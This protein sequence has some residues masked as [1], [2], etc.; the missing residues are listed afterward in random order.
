MSEAIH[1]FEFYESGVRDI[2]EKFLRYQIVARSL[3][4]AYQKLE[5]I[6]VIKENRSEEDKVRKSDL[7]KL[8]VCVKLILS[9]GKPVK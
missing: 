8:T 9:G 1:V 6:L 2:S 5:D 4:E 7:R 3:P